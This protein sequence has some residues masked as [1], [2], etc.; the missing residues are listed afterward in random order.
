MTDDASPALLLSVI[1]PVHNV[2]SYL[3]PCLESILTQSASDVEVIVVD[4]ASTDSSL[5][6]AER[7]TEEY[8]RLRTLSLPDNVGLGMA[9]NAGIDAASGAYLMFVDGDDYVAQGSLAAICQSL[10]RTSPD[11]LVF[12]YARTYPS[13]RIRQSRR[14]FLLTS[15]VTVTFTLADRPE[16]LTLFMAVWNRVYRRRFVDDNR[17]RFPSGYY[18]DLPWTYPA[19]FS[20]NSIAILPRVCYYYRQRSH[21]NILKSVGRRHFDV[22]EQYR[23]VFEFIESR[24]ELQ[25]WTPAMCGRMVSHFLAI[26]AKGSARLDPRDRREFFKTASRL[27]NQFPE[28]ESDAVS[29]GD[30]LRIALLRRGWYDVFQATKRA[31][32]TY[33]AVRRATRSFRRL[34]RH[35]RI[36][37]GGDAA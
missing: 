23:R 9:R 21:G 37:S 19:M 25:Q 24:P 17:I 3:Q 35:R 7:M 6:V 32:M 15:S 4:D 33:L 31:N 28:C 1:I 30:R 27:V 36:R 18:E 2:E 16:L 13:G 11:V 34:L 14:S 10:R 26:L 8:P 12:D 5:S 22:F 20:A 29:R